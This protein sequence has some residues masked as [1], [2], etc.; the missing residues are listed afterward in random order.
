MSNLSTLS[1]DKPQT[2]WRPMVWTLSI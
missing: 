1:K 2:S